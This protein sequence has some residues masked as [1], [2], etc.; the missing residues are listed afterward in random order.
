MLEG[1]GATVG[2]VDAPF[3]P[4]GGAYGFRLLVDGANGTAAPPPTAG[5]QPELTVRV[6]LHKPSAELLAAE[7]S[8]GM[9]TW[10]VSS[11]F[12]PSIT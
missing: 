6:D 8:P 5:A 1:L 10:I 9:C 7:T 11:I 4:E 3:D 12:T 2:E